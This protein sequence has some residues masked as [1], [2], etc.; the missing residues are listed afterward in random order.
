M[1]NVFGVC[2][3]VEL[4]EARGGMTFPM[5]VLYPVPLGGENGESRVASRNSVP[6]VLISHGSGGSPA[7]YQT[8]ARRLA[9]NGFFVGMPE[10]PFNNRH[11]NSL[12]G[13]LENLLNRPKH[14]RAAVDWFFD[15]PTLSPFLKP[16]S[17]ALIG[18]SMGGCTALVAA[19]GVP[20]FPLPGG[21]P[22]PTG[23]EPDPRLKTLVLLA[24]AAAWFWKKGA[25]DKVNVPILILVGEKDKHTPYERH[26]KLV[27]EG[28]PDRTKIQCE[29][30]GN[31]GHYSFLDPFPRHLVKESFPP[32]WDPS[33][34]DRAGFHEELGFVVLNFF[35]R[36]LAEPHVF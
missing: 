4:V 14:I 7:L 20:A 9:G 18:H 1:E 6:L 35:R 15:N 5:T 10:H 17:F 25:L 16:D 23:M 27:I 13:T 31:A 2:G 30:V 3:S 11:D 24:P 8:L 22:V 36:T 12:A 21:D 19:G 29:I 26:A 34:F 28:V 32:S 33:G